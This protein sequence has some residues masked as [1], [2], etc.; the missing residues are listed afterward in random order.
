MFDYFWFFLTDRNEKQRRVKYS[1]LSLARSGNVKALGDLAKLCRDSGDNTTAIKWYNKIISLGGVNAKNAAN[2]I[3]NIHYK[4][5]R[6][7]QALKFYEQAA[8]QGLTAAKK[9]IGIIYQE[10]EQWEA[11]IS[12]FKVAAYEGDQIAKG[13]LEKLLLRPTQSP[14]HSWQEAE[15]LAQRWMFYFGFHDAKVTAAGTDGGIDVNSARAIAQVKYEKS[16]TGRPELQKLAGVAHDEDKSA[17]FFS[18]S[19]YTKNA[20]AWAEQSRIGLAL[21]KYDYSGNVIGVNQAAKRML[22]AAKN[23]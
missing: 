23:Q 18:L 5:R 13:R 8:N 7:D 21:F 17:L 3:G 15:R 11:A 12:W 6:Y 16:T 2:N 4:L 9:N 19:G 14:I 22:T 10:R 20:L 1:L